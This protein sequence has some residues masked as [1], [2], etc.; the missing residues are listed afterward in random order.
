M[1]G[2]PGC[3]HF[4]Q[5]EI[6]PNPRGN[7]PTWEYRPASELDQEAEDRLDE[8][9]HLSRSQASSVCAG[10]FH[11][12]RSIGS[13]GCRAE[14]CPELSRGSNGGGSD[15]HAE[16]SRGS[17]G[18]G[19]EFQTEG[20]R[21]HDGYGGEVSNESAEAIEAVAAAQAPAAATIGAEMAH[22]QHTAAV[23]TME[24]EDQ[25]TIMLNKAEGD[26]LGL[27]LEVDN[28][29]GALTVTGIYP[30]LVQEWNSKHPDRHACPGD[31]IVQVNDVSGS[32]RDMLAEL[33]EPSPAQADP[34]GKYGGFSWT[35]VITLKRR[36]KEVY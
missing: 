6:P 7:E 9:I 8:G 21:E 4:V 19:G 25:F 29:E 10:D 5:G 28:E 20:C 26:L 16:Q 14:N 17:N 27:D 11:K 1:G 34:A 33:R 3:C 2:V 24:E 32:A 12:E 31:D 36:L 15:S 18:F 13:T 30:G 35:Y 23:E 22:F